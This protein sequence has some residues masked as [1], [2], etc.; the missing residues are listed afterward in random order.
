MKL[1]LNR[2]ERM[3]AW[4]RQLG[5][6]LLAALTAAGRDATVRAVLVTGAG[7]AFSGGADLKE[8]RSAEA[9]SRA[10]CTGR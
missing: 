10:R 9:M 5:L 6:D 3:N 1:E 7:R 2:P 8:G 4:D